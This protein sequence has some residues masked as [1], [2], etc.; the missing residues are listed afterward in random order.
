ML[1]NSRCILILWLFALVVGCQP[2]TPLPA[3]TVTSEPLPSLTVETGQIFFIRN[4]NLWTMYLDGSHLRQLTADAPPGIGYY[5]PDDQSTALV[6]ASATQVE[7]DTDRV[8]QI[9]IPEDCQTPH[10]PGHD[11]S[12][13]FDFRFSPSGRYVSFIVGNYE[14][15]ESVLRVLD[16]QA[17]TC[18][19]VEGSDTL[20]AWLPNDRALVAMARCEYGALSLYDPPTAHTKF[21]GYGL[22]GGWN[23]DQTAFF[24]TIPDYIGWANVLWAYNLQVDAFVHQ[25]PRDVST[26]QPGSGKTE[27]AI[28]WT[29]DGTHLLYAGRQLS[30]TYNLTDSLPS[31]TTFGPSQLY[32]VDNLGQYDRVL[33]DDPAHNY[34]SLGQDGEQLIIRRTPY[35]PFSISTGPVDRSALECPLY[36]RGCSSF[37]DFLLDWRTGERTPLTVPQIPTATPVASVTVPDLNSQPVYTALDGSFALYPGNNGT[38]LWRV[39]ASGERVLL[40]ADGHHFVYVETQ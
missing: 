28:G 10:L 37:E 11:N 35:Q 2:G 26:N 5:I 30:Y 13:V 8:R 15:G 17:G 38:G 31:T 12:R 34:F 9:S 24:A 18:S 39:S 33:I 29:S 36:G 25:P 3:A 40:V 22:V 7:L 1:R 16:S 23:Q 14:C 32:I 27:T 19:E 6:F 4:D 20:V 21:L